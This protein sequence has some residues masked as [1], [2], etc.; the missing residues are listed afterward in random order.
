MRKSFL[1]ALVCAVSMIGFASSARCDVELSGEIN[2]IKG[3]VEILKSGETVWDKAENG[4]QIEENDRVRT[5]PRSSCDIELDDGSM[6]HVAANSE[7][8]LEKLDLKEDEHTS[9]FKLYFGKVIASISKLRKTKMEVRT[10]TS[11]CAVRGTE[12]AVETTEAETNVGVF[13]GQV[14]VANPDAVQTDTAEVLVNPDQETTVE[15]GINPKVPASLRAA[16][17]KNR[18]RMLEMRMRV[19]ALREKLKRVPPAERM[20]ARLAAKE[21]IQNIRDK[22]K[23]QRENLRERRDNLKQQRRAP[24]RK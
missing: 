24:G 7:T 9:S 15:K 4:L 11:V 2:D 5:K 10:P 17:I 8:T 6:I 18:E 16:M 12:F 21:R 13:E 14:A 23:G 19:K 22:R 3:T 20:K 1:F